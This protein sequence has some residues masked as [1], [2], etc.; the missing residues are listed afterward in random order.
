MF[1][2]TKGENVF[3]V[4]SR[5]FLLPKLGNLSR[6]G[7]QRTHFSGLLG[8]G[9][10]FAQDFSVAHKYT[11]SSSRSSR[12]IVVADV[13]LGRVKEVF[14]AHYHLQSPPDEYLSKIHIV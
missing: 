3:G 13:A 10:Y 9:V 11:T 6:F 1:H 7:L 12:F 5:G 14:S 8:C 2:G 4:L